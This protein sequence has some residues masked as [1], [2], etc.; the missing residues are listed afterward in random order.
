MKSIAK[1]LRLV[2]VA[3]LCV[4]ALL[5]LL[6]VIPFNQQAS[7]LLNSSFPPDQ[8]SPL[9]E[10]QEV[11][12]VIAKE[13]ASSKFDVKAANFSSPTP[14]VK[15]PSP[16]HD[17]LPLIPLV[18][19]QIDIDN[20]IKSSQGQI[21]G[22]F[23]ELLRNVYHLWLLSFDEENVRVVVPGIIIPTFNDGDHL[24]NLLLNFDAP[25]RHI[26]FINNAPGRD[27]D[28]LVRKIMDTLQPLQDAGAISAYYFPENAGFSTS[29]NIGIRRT[30]K[31]LATERVK[32]HTNPLWFFIVNCDSVFRPGSAQIFARAV[33]AQLTMTDDQ[34][35]ADFRKKNPG[36]EMR[37][38]KPGLFY[39]NHIVDHFCF[40]ISEEAVA[41]AGDMDESFYPAYME[42][43]DWRWRVHLAGF[44]DFL[45][46]ASV[47]HH[48]SVNLKKASPD[49]PFMQMLGRTARGWEYGRMKWGNIAQ[50]KLR[51]PIPPTGRRSPFGIKNAPVSLYVVDP[52]HRRCVLTGEGPKFVGSSVCWYNGSVLLPYLPRGTQLPKFLEHPVKLMEQYYREESKATK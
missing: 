10:V 44:E 41:A 35:L 22:A 19:K 9:P 30:R 43:V 13:G 40:A 2:I 39:T 12:D 26:T 24:R 20:Y 16:H 27:G 11:V 50:E 32:P 49:S 33:N 34:R 48:R 36:N 29:I 15:A 38:K 1:P 3:L 31:V 45:T 7:S 4:I 51:S 5:I 23:A 6:L 52:V 42:D 18:K 28:P 8:G 47:G 46:G 25:F 37:P 21:A 14:A 17:P